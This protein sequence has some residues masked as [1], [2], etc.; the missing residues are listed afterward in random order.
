MQKLFLSVLCCTLISCASFESTNSQPTASSQPTETT[1][2]F[3]RHGKTILNTLIRAQ[4]WADSALTEAGEQVA[5]QVGKGLNAEGVKF[6]SAYSSDMGRSIATANILLK[7]VGQDNLKVETRKNLR[8]FSFG[9]YEASYDS[10]MWGDVADYLGLKSYKEIYTYDMRKSVDA[11]HEVDKAKQAKASVKVNVAEKYDTVIKRLNMAVNDIAKK[12]AAAGG[13]NVLII[14]HGMGLGALA[15]SLD[16]SY[17]TEGKPFANAA[18]MKVVYN[19]GKYSIK[20]YAETRYLDLGKH[21]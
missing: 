18:V 10:E 8:E 1:L 11:L 20:E 16:P 6:V 21:K 14:G 2:Y 15:N 17:V 9:S 19:N 13:G 12:T 4:G 7:E 5:Q 3:V